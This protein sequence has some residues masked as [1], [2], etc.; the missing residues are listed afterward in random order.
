MH[1]SPVEAAGQ[2]LELQLVVEVASPLLRGEAPPC[3]L[4]GVP[5]R[6]GDGEL[7]DEPRA[8]VDVAECHDGLVHVRVDGQLEALPALGREGVVVDLCVQQQRQAVLLAQLDE[9]EGIH[10]CSVM[11]T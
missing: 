9:E 8:E 10:T 3:R 5:Q 6:R 4:G 1:S 2:V 11:S 7:G